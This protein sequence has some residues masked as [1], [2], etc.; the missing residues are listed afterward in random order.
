MT[1]SSAISSDERRFRRHPDIGLEA[2]NFGPIERAHIDLRP[3]TIFVGPGNTGKT[4]LATLIYSLHTILMGFRRF[5]FWDDPFY[6]WLASINGSDHDFQEI[7]PLLRGQRQLRKF[8]DLPDHLCDEMQ[9]VFEISDF[10]PKHLKTELARC[11]NV[12]SPARLIRS[13]SR[14]NRIYQQTFDRTASIS[15]TAKDG[16]DELWRWESHISRASGSSDAE[17]ESSGRIQDIEC[18]AGRSVNQLRSD[19][20]RLERSHSLRTRL[21]TEVETSWPIYKEISSLVGATTSR[22]P[23]VYYLPAARSGIIESHRMIAG[24]MVQRATRPSVKHLET[25]TWS[26]VEADFVK[27]LVLY[28][29]ADTGYIGSTTARNAEVPIID[30]ARQIET[31]TIHGE[32]VT[33][34]VVSGGYP[35]FVYRRR[36]ES[37]EVPLSSASS[38]VTE[39]A[40]VILFIRNN[41][42]SGDTLIFE[43][44]EAH[45]HPSAQSQI[46]TT[47]AQLVR[48][49]VRV[50][51]TTHSDWILKA[52]GNL[53][54]EGEMTKR[55]RQSERQKPPKCSLDIEEVG[56]W[57][58]RSPDEHSGTVVD[59]IKF[60]QDSGIEPSDYEDVAEHL[61]NQFVG[62][63]NRLEHSK[64]NSESNYE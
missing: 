24:A 26:G 51:V 38:M 54:L 1:A 59:E 56:V 45:L 12:T 11:F 49:G 52:I 42:H 9:A 36:G 16:P 60:D 25:P 62:L 19:W 47:L 50:I 63:H 18:I 33:K 29:L 6:E 5:P 30:I 37:I 10:L 28:D 17:I 14:Y 43:E 55:T 4:Y 61:Y 8:S 3:L 44:P 40:P 46:A 23:L 22:Q 15:L 53:M 27:Q 2:T 7:L 58:F 35:E 34:T 39:L 31:D 32:I 20:K 41:I 57:S 21:A 64:S 13:Q 48:A